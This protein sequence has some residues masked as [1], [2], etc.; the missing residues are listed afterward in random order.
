MLSDIKYVFTSHNGFTE[1]AVEALV[2]IDT[3]PNRKEKGF[4]FDK[5]APYDC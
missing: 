2:H 3:I 4:V 1:N 5:T